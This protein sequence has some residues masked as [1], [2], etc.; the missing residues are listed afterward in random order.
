MIIFTIIS[1]IKNDSKQNRQKGKFSPFASPTRE[2]A[3]R[4]SR[5]RNSDAQKAEG[6]VPKKVLF[7]WELTFDP[8]ADKTPKVLWNKSNIHKNIGYILTIS[9]IIG[10]ILAAII[11]I[12]PHQISG[13]AR[14]VVGLRLEI[15]YSTSIFIIILSCLI[16]WSGN[17]AI[18]R[19][20]FAWVVVGS[21][22]SIF[23]PGLAAYIFNLHAIGTIS[24]NLLILV[25]I[26]LQLILGTISLILTLSSRY[27]FESELSL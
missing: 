6:H 3:A 27:I 21:G 1:N 25:L 16:L 15:Y 20:S 9:S 8:L 24:L 13:L 17:H 23:I 12:L 10:F 2:P 19:L 18:K 5:S 7:S 14:A 4:R 11:F 22:Y 26:I